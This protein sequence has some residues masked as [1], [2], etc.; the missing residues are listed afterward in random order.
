MEAA[1]ACFLAALAQQEAFPE[2]HSNLS[3]TFGALGQTD[4]ATACHRRAIEL[5]PD[6]ADCHNNLG[7]ALIQAGSWAEAEGS[8]QR[9]LALRPDFVRAHYNLGILRHEQRRLP[10]A[11]EC[12]RQ[13]IAL[14]PDWAEA[15]NELGCTLMA[16]RRLDEAVAQFRSSLEIKPEI[17]D[18]HFNLSLALSACGDL[19]EGWVEYEWRWQTGHMAGQQ[20]YFTQPQWLGEPAEGRT[21]L[22]RAEGGFGDTLQFCRYAPLAAMLGWT[23]YF[24]VQPEL[25]RLLRDLP[26]VARVI[27]SGAPRPAFDMVCPMLS[28]PRAF[29]TRLL[30]ASLGIS[31][32]QRSISWRPAVFAS[33][34]PRP[35]QQ[36]VLTEDGSV[37][38]QQHGNTIS[39]SARAGAL[40]FDRAKPDCP[41]HES[42]RIGTEEEDRFVN[43]RKLPSGR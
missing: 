3:I 18:T 43:S 34:V 8:Y 1:I 42:S 20:Q 30:R 24:E 10:E 41:R 19:P 15:F 6:N 7:A 26:G 12:F 2:A 23:V 39:C 33:R 40:A 14:Q 9:A 35:G 25:A 21:L 37:R 38:D 17:P 13:V 16:Q 28:L 5:Q 22:I 36:Q 11:A 31:A 32:R 27:A 29:G 4:E